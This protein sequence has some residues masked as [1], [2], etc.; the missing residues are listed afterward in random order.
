MGEGVLCHFF[1]KSV[2]PLKM[3]MENMLIQS[4]VLTGIGTIF[5]LDKLCTYFARHALK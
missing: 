2:Y 4:K 3:H 1:S 5:T